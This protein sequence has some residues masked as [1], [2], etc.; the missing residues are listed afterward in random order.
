M[1]DGK[2]FHQV[3]RKKST[4]AKGAHPFALPKA[5]GWA[6]SCNASP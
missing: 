2:D 4:L 6:L 1:P 3:L 5:Q